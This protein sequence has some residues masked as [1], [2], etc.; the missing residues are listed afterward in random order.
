MYGKHYQLDEK[1]VN[2]IANWYEGTYIFQ[3]PNY[4]FTL[5]NLCTRITKVVGPL[6]IKLYQSLLFLPIMFIPL[7]F[8]TRLNKISIDDSFISTVLK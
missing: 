3:R 5:K 7:S 4:L 2:L 6:V 1:R 8:K